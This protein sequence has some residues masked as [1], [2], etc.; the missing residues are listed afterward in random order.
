MEQIALNVNVLMDFTS[1]QEQIN[2]IA[3]K[4]LNVSKIIQA[5]PL[6]N[7]QLQIK[8]NSYLVDNLVKDI[9]FALAVFHLIKHVQ[10]AL[11]LI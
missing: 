8:Y 10:M 1:M 5:L 2:V 3:V 7:V 6:F 9:S 11:F 4:M